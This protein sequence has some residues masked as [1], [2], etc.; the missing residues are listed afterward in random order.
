VYSQLEAAVGEFGLDTLAASTR[1]LA[2]S[3]VRDATYTSIENTLS[4]LGSSRDA[5]AG[6]MRS[7]LLGAAFGGQPVS[8]SLAAQ[9]I[10]K[11]NALLDVAAALAR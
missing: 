5:V 1:A 4:R 9:L 10:A 2:S 8:A 6:A 3:S 7:A 11:G